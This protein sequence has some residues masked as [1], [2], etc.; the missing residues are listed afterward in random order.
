MS[1]PQEILDDPF[2]EWVV[3]EKGDILMMFEDGSRKVTFRFN[4]ATGLNQL[5]ESA[6]WAA[7]MKAI[8]DTQ[9]FEAAC[10]WAVEVL[11]A[12]E[13]DIEVTQD[14]INDL[15]DGKHLPST[16]D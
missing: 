8:F 9:G 10:E 13:E 6:K 16:D 3:T 12:G 14:D 4:A 1:E 2:H 5:S 7:K 11:G 15:L